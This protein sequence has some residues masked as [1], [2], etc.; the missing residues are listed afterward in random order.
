MSS[1]NES[2]IGTAPRA[3]AIVRW[4]GVALGVVVLAIGG[5]HAIRHNPPPSFMAGGPFTLTASDGRRIS[6]SDFRGKWELIYF[7]YTYCPDVCP[8]TLSNL[9]DAMAALGPKAALVQPIFITV[10]PERDT[11]QVLA[12]FAGGFDP[13]IVALTG[14]PEEIA[15][16]ERTFDVYAAK[17][18]NDKEPSA[19]LMNHTSLL[20]LIDPEGHPTAILPASDEGPKLAAA[21]APYLARK[22]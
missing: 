19:Y 11:P 9:S 7:G 6:D 4:A 21:L 3:A 14:T 5:Y 18:P 10:D 16:V 2:D 8:L 13:R 20:Y 1:E 17:A 15:A 22:S 12:A